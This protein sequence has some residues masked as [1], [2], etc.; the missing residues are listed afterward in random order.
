MY[1]LVFVLLPADPQNNLEECWAY[2]KRYYKDNEVAHRFR[3]LNKLSMFVRKSGSA[4]LRGKA[5]EISDF[6]KPLLALWEEKMDATDFAHVQIQAMLTLNVKMESMMSEQAGEFKFPPEAAKTF[7]ETAF[8]MCQLQVMLMNHFKNDPNVPAFNFT[9]KNHHMLHSAKL[10]EH[11]NPRL[12]WCFRG[13]DMMQRLQ[14]L[15][16]ACVRGVNG[17]AASIKIAQRYRL[18][19]HLQYSKKD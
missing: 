9:Q 10:A 16:K 5:A 4:K 6:G 3:Y 1:M 7:K 12:L 19:L 13:E 11:I 15:A 18:A 2:I 17:A 14:T 8:Q